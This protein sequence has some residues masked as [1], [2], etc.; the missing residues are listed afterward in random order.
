M[1]DTTSDISHKD[2]MSIIV[3]FVSEE[4]EA[5]ER[6]L[7]IKEIK[8]KTGKNIAGNMLQIFAQL[9]LDINKLIGKFPMYYIEYRICYIYL[10]M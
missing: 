1:A 6:L 5:E 3:R 7:Y 8:S 2:M 4:G 10:I 9:D